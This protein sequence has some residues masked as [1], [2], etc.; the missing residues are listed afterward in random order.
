MAEKNTK[1]IE[2]F[3][4]LL[5]ALATLLALL[6]VLIQV[7]LM[8]GGTTYA[9]VLLAVAIWFLCIAGNRSVPF[10]IQSAQ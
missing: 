1:R 10:L 5:F 4:R 3:L 7:G 2:F 8:E 9:V 6:A